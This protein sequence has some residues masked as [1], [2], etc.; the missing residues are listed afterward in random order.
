MARNTA[1]DAIKQV[2]LEPIT[3]PSI[4]I[5]TIG[6]DGPLTYKVIFEISPEF[7]LADMKNMALEKLNSEVTVEKVEE[8]LQKLR[9]QQGEW[10]EVDRAAAKDDKMTVDFVGKING[11]EFKGGT[12]KGFEIEL[13]AGRM[14]P[15]F[16]EQLIG[17]KAGDELTV[18]VTFPSDYAAD[19]AG[20]EAEF[21]TTV[22]KVSE[23]SLPEVNEEFIKKFGIFDGDI[24]KLREQL[25]QRLQHELDNRLL[26]L[27]KEHVLNKMLELN[28][29]EMPKKLVL[30]EVEE[31]KRQQQIYAKQMGMANLPID[32]SAL[33][34]RAETRV[35]LGILV[36]KY[37]KLNSLSADEESV[38]KLVENEASSY[39]HPEHVVKWFYEKPE[40]LSS[41]IVMALEN[42]VVEDIIAK[43]NVQ[44]KQLAYDEAMKVKS[45]LA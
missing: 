20:K 1:P 15:G 34:K 43:A 3:H 45:S 17:A 31:L 39:E 11:E 14:I 13:G 4:E 27:N 37:A 8:T 25:Q 19:L 26:N 16:E 9:H 18:K 22:H 42:K 24:E 21:L 23:I 41:Y 30:S 44:A 5:I 12:A 38:R 10:K 7:A 33:H 28:Q 6:A 29:F 35:K 36:N 40:R 2:N 32:E